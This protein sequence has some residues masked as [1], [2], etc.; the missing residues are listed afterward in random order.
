MQ[1][2]L[3]QIYRIDNQTKF[4]RLIYEADDNKRNSQILAYLNQ[5]G[6]INY[7]DVKLCPN[8]HV[9]TLQK[10]LVMDGGGV[11]ARKIVKKAKPLEQIRFFMKIAYKFGKYYSS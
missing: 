11:V 2:D 8:G 7:N 5:I 4:E 3:P 6:F 9:M 1:I 10:Q